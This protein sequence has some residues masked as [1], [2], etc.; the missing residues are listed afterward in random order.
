M[1][2]VVFSNSI[3]LVVYYLYTHILLFNMFIDF[4]ITKHKCVLLVNDIL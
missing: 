1:I 2:H 4:P 3:I